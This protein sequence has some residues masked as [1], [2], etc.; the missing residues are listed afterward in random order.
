MRSEPFLLFPRFQ[1]LSWGG[2]MTG[3]TQIKSLLA[4]DSKS[5]A[6]GVAV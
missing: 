5:L 4:G 6:T 2:T 3:Y 1:S